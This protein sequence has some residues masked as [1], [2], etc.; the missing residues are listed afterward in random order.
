MPTDS[1]T[2]RPNARPEILAAAAIVL[3]LGLLIV[4]LRAVYALGWLP[5]S[6]WTGPVPSVGI[7]FLLCGTI[8]LAQAWHRP[9]VL[10]AAYVGL[11]LIVGARLV[12]HA[13][14]GYIDAQ[15]WLDGALWFVHQDMASR[16]AEMFLAIAIGL[17]A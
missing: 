9:E 16:S 10:R 7:C 8:L 15:P 17:I 3:T 4:V 2:A 5:A 11:L 6:A 1:P 14:E 13:F 12:D